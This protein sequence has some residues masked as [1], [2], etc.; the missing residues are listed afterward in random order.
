MNET[1]IIIV[2]ILIYIALLSLCIMKL[3]NSNSKKMIKIILAISTIVFIIGIIL[4][5]SNITSHEWVK[6]LNTSDWE[7]E[8][9]LKEYVEANKVLINVKY[10]GGI[11]LIILSYIGNII[12]IIKNNKKLEKGQ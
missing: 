8:L 1:L 10:Y 2:F 12:T 7:N 5:A 9:D 11:L 3:I 6:M 4:Y